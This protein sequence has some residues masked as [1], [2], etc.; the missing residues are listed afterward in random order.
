VR[1]L[2]A[3]NA[4]IQLIS[5]SMVRALAPFAA[6]HTK[7]HHKAHSEDLGSD[8]LELAIEI[9]YIALATGSFFSAVYP[10]TYFKAA[11]LLCTGFFVLLATM[12]ADFGD[13]S[14]SQG[15]PLMVM[16]VCVIRLI[17]GYTQPCIFRH[18]GEIEPDHREELSRWVAVTQT[19]V[20]FL[21]AWVVFA[22]VE[23]GNI[24]S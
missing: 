9:S 2:A 23:T 3:I 14:K 19:I 20:N 10:T 11:T 22:L 18:I 6:Y 15:A 21:G 16:C 5:W 17:D 1:H 8:I 4:F 12:A 24:A 13:W 7:H